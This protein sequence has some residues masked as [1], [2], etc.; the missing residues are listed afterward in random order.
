M[1]TLVF[2]SFVF[3]TK[4]PWNFIINCHVLKPACPVGRHVAIEHLQEVGFLP[5]RLAG[6]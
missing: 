1:A 2:D 6:G 4:V 3:G 5:D